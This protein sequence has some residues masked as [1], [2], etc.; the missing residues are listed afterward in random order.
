MALESHIHRAPTDADICA[1]LFS[2][3]IGAQTLVPT[4]AEAASRSGGRVGGGFR[5]MSTSRWE[6]KKHIITTLHITA[7]PPPPLPFFSGDQ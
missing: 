2:V 6:D 5:K 7:S 4:E 3:L 1:G